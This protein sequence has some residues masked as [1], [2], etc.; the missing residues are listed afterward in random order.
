MKRNVLRGTLVAALIGT[1]V[2]AVPASAEELRAK[3]QKAMR[4]V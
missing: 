4:S 2:L 3:M 1:S